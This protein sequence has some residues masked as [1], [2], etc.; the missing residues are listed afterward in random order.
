MRPLHSID[1]MSVND[2]DTV[3]GILI[4]Q[5]DFIGNESILSEDLNYTQ[6]RVNIEFM[7]TGFERIDTLLR[8]KKRGR[9]PKVVT[10]DQTT[11]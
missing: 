7:K 6:L 4:S 5:V 9:K 1:Y 3:I 10:N 2:I 8:K 11:N